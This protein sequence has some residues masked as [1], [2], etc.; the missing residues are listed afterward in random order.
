MTSVVLL[1][2]PFGVGENV[3]EVLATGGN[4]PSG[5]NV[6]EALIELLSSTFKAETG[7][8]VSGDPMAMQRLE[9]AEKAKIE[10]SSAQATDINLPFLMQTQQVQHLNMNLTRAKFEQLI[11]D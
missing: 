1:I 8:D 5:D 11:G 10:L 9:A 2:S 7:V 4:N 3:V 6:D